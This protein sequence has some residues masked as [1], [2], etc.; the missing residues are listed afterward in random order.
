M[1]L[2]HPLA[3]GSNVA[4]AL[5]P[6]CF[7]K[8]NYADL[9][10]DPNNGNWYCNDGC[11][12]RYDPWRLPPRRTEDISLQ[13]ARIDP[14]DVATY[15]PPVPVL[16]PADFTPGL[17][18]NGLVATR[19]GGVAPFANF[20]ASDPVNTGAW[21][22][23]T[24]IV[25]SGAVQIVGLSSAP[26]SGLASVGATASS[27]GYASDGTKRSNGVSSAYGA[28][29]G[30]GDVVGVAW[31]ADTGQ[32]TFYVN[33]AT[34]GVAFTNAQGLLAPTGSIGLALMSQAMNF[35]TIST[36]Y[37]PPAGYSTF[38]NISTGYPYPANMP[39]EEGVL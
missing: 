30:A 24:T 37:I 23:E 18:L 19:N 11:V 35:G 28:A 4:I 36:K 34:Q 3:T 27:W 25:G 13:H 1:S 10:Q 17:A 21:Y 9:R 8:V 14:N 32:I 15:Y 29:F 7:K 6:R 16:S 33:N 20:R 39:V 12:D 31:S 2:W 5:C 26:V 22:W 38:V